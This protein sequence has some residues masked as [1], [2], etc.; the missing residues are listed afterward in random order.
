MLARSWW[1]GPAPVSFRGGDEASQVPGESTAY[2]PCSQ[3]PARPSCPVSSAPRCCLPK[4]RNSSALTSDCSRGS[5]ARPA[6]SLSTLRSRGRPRTTQDSLPV[7]DQ[8]CPDGLGY[9]QDSKRGF[10]MSGH[11]FSSTK[12][13]L[14]HSHPMLGR[15]G[16]GPDQP[17]LDRLL[18]GIVRAFGREEPAPLQQA[19]GAVADPSAKERDVLVGRR[20]QGLEHGPVPGRGGR[21]GSP[22]PRTP[23]AGSSRCTIVWDVNPLG[24]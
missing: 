20:W 10:V 19:Q 2:M 6:G 13:C 24:S 23:A 3:T 11:R 8:P 12:L 21:T 1:T 18:A 22:R 14:A 15:A 5:L 9:P 7:G 4:M 17:I 16:S